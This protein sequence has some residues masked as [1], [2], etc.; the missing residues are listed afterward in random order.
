MTTT[1]ITYGPADRPTTVDLTP[2]DI[3]NIETTNGA[4]VLGTF[5]SLSAAKGVRLHDG[6]KY[7]TRRVASIAAITVGRT[8]EL[9]DEDVAAELPAPAAAPVEVVEK[10][11]LVVAPLKVRRRVSRGVKRL[12]EAPSEAISAKGRTR[13]YSTPEKAAQHDAADARHAARIAAPVEV[14]PAAPAPVVTVSDVFDPD[15]IVDGKHLSELRF[16]EVMKLAQKYRT[17]GRGIARI[18]ALREGVA[19]AIHAETAVRIRAAAALIEA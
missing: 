18:A 5:V 6:R 7:V 17:P 13:D 10:P 16:P 8:E 12:G 2:G 19:R 11:E 3:V 1:Q 4:Q 9:S 14:A 15:P